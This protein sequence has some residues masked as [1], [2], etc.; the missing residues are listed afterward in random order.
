GFDA[1]AMHA[2]DALVLLDA[3][4][5]VRAW[6]I[7]AEAVIGYQPREV[8]GRAFRELIADTAVMPGLLDGSCGEFLASLQMRHADGRILE[9]SATVARWSEDENWRIGLRIEEAPEVEHE[10]MRVA[11]FPELNPTPVF[12][13]SS[14]G[15]LLYMNP[16]M[17]DLP[18]ETTEEMVEGVTHMTL[19]PDAT[20][21]REIHC[22]S[23]W[24]EQH[25]HHTREWDSI[26]TYVVDISERKAAE[27]ELLQ[28]HESLERK[29]VE[30]THDLQREIEIR[31]EA[32]E[33]AL[34]ANHAKST[35]LA[36]MSHELRTP[37]NA[38]IG[39]SELLREES[40]T[41]EIVPDLEKILLASHQLLGLINELLDLSKIEAG[42]LVMN[43][44][45]VDVAD[46]LR[47]SASTVGPLAQARHNQIEVDV[48]PEIGL[49]QSDPTRLRQVVMNLMGNAAKFTHHGVIRASC[50]RTM[51]ADGFAWVEV[52]ISDTGIGIPR[53]RLHTIF[54]AFVQVDNSTTREY[55][56]TGLGLAI[57]HKLCGMLGGGISVASTLGQGST[58]TVRIPLR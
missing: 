14:D 48:D 39:F 43:F 3:A 10:L 46:L 9:C 15:E 26:R 37:L 32:E 19:A 18:E 53:D 33:R 25:V 31:R 34:S 49:V 12:E 24:Y 52:A 6:N 20:C 21:I 22:N 42:R 55:G 2:P 36:T 13:I 45:D 40:E 16:A 29:V 5:D 11:S 17:L 47:E 38:I 41:G 27:L 23:K 7:A 35:F 8:I 58:F 28:A 4:G 44:Q 51:D 57:C 1:W 50:R 56:G 30:R 54:D